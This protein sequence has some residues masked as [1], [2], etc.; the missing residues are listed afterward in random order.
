MLLTLVRSY[1]L[2]LLISVSVCLIG[3]LMSAFLA[4]PPQGREFFVSFVYYWNG[5]VVA[6]TG[7]GALHFGIF[8]FK[9][10]FHYL[11]SE[12][13]EPE[14]EAE[15]EIYHN[16]NRLISWRNKQVIAIPVFVVGATILYICGY[17]MTGLPHFLLW[18]SSSVMFYVGGMMLAYTIHM[19]R[20]FS[21]FERN[22]DRVRL[23]KG[24][25]IFEM[26]NFNLYLSTLFFAGAVALYFAFRGTLTA[27]FTFVPPF[28]WA[29]H[30][31]NSFISPNESYR[32]VR[33]LLIYPVL[34][35]VPYGILAGFYIRLVLRKIYLTSIKREITEIDELA[36]PLI[37]A[38]GTRIAGDR[39]IEIRNA[40][41]DLKGKIIRENGVPS[42]INLRDSPSIVLLV[43]I[44][45]QF[46]VHND[47]TINGFLSSLL[48]VN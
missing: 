42:L 24:V 25:H 27:N 2:W 33:N 3:T 34:I 36:K 6:T 47:G 43:I 12:I 4:A 35:F 19:I 45:I 32:S 20:L 18:L 46:I 48:G 14:P 28:P 39:A 31:V 16:L 23:R 17:P 22:L 38:G 11:T 7:A 1:T 10:Q 8:T 13:L 29:D 26:E 30:L 9:Q 21:A 5:L 15:G 44:A 40:V 37:Q 41:M